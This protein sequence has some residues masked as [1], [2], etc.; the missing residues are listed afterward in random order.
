MTESG[1]V[2]LANG[3]PFPPSSSPQAPWQNHVR[4]PWNRPPPMPREGE[5]STICSGLPPVNMPP[6]QIR[7]RGNISNC[8]FKLYL[9]HKIFKGLYNFL[10]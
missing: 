5:H 3:P 4:L 2:L 7:P 8:K 9:I 6:P 10:L 1:T